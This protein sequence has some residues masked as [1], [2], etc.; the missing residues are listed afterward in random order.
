ML[1]KG[2]ELI[3][4]CHWTE[5]ETAASPAGPGRS[6]SRTPRWPCSTCWAAAPVMT[7]DFDGGHH[8]FHAAPETRPQ[9]SP[10]ASE[11]G[12]DLRIAGRSDP[13]RSAL[14]SL[15]RSAGRRSARPS[16]CAATI[17]T[18]WPTRASAAWPAATARRRS[19]PAPSATCSGPAACGPTDPR[20]WSGCF[21]SIIRPSGS[22]MPAE[23]WT[24]CAGSAR[25]TAVRPVRTGSDRGQGPQRHREDAHRD[26]PHPQALPRRARVE[27]RAIR[28]SPTSFR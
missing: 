20:R 24:S 27:E 18:C 12:L 21:I 26:R 7:Q 14:E 28:W 8:A 15:F 11:H 9:R 4:R 5:A 3:D 2:K 6:A 23:P 19:G 22:Q 1:V 10:A 25:G 17:R 13:G 16:R